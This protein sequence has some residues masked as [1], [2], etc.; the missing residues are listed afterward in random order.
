M[1]AEVPVLGGAGDRAGKGP[2]KEGE[3]GGSQGEKDSCCERD[4][5][6]PRS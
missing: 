5:P 3:G 2:E 1:K 4:A 6:S